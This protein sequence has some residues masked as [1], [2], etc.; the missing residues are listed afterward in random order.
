MCLKQFTLSNLILIMVY[1]NS[2]KNN[3]VNS[4][5]DEFVD[6]IWSY[7]VEI[8]I[9]IV[10]RIRWLRLV[11]LSETN[12][13]KKCTYVHVLNVSVFCTLCLSWFVNLLST[14]FLHLH[15]HTHT[16]REKE[17]SFKSCF[18]DII[19]IDNWLWF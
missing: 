19:K 16:Q 8:N 4:Y 1:S 18:C 3:Y 2:I 17:N 6:S 11:K 9:T 14:S 12:A 10:I 15:T 13:K 5:N 7:P